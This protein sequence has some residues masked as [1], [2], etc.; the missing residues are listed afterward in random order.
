MGK[1]AEFLASSGL[2]TIEPSPADGRS[3]LIGLTK[4]GRRLHKKALPLWRE[5]QRKFEQL[6]GAE[7]VTA[8][9]KGLAEMVVSDDIH[10]RDRRS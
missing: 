6:N 5:A 9:R 8:L 3:R 7:R 10:D 2:V 4:K 1:M